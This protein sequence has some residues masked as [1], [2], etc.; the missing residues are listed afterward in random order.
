MCA[1]W[2]DAAFTENDTPLAILVT[3]CTER[4]QIRDTTEVSPWST[5]VVIRC[6]L[7]NTFSTMFSACPCMKR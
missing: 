2:S 1:S 5:G 4:L 6:A 7:T 3:M